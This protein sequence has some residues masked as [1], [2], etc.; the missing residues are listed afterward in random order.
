[1]AEELDFESEFQAV[2]RADPIVPFTIVLTN[3]DRHRVDH[4]SMVSTGLDVVTVIYPS[5]RTTI[6]FFNIVSF[7][8]HEPALRQAP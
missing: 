1:M 2:L 7:E 4:P 5:V 8:V 3:G 6:R